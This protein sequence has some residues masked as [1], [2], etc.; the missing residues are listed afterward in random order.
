[1]KRI[2]L[3]IGL[4]VFCAC[5]IVTAFA[6]SSTEKVL[7]SFSNPPANPRDGLVADQA[8]NLYGTA[9]GGG[10]TNS[11]F[12]FK[13]SAPATKGGAWSET[14]LYSFLGG[15][16]D[17]R[18]PRGG[19]VFD[20]A[21][22]LYGTTSYGGANNFGTIFEVSPPSTLGATWV[23]T[24]LY[25]F[26]SHPD[27]FVPWAG[28]I[29]DQA[30]NLY[31]TTQSGGSYACGT[32]FE[33][34]PPATSGGAWTE[35]VIYSF[36]GGHD[37][38]YPVAGLLM[39]SGG[40]LLGTTEYGGACFSAGCGTV[41]RLHYAQ[42]SWTETVLHRFNA[43]EGTQPVAGLTLHGGSFF[44]TTVTGGTAQQGTVFQL[45]LSSSGV[46][47]LLMIHQFGSSAGDGGTPYSGVAF[48][49]AGNLYGTTGYGS[50][51]PGG[52]VY[53]L[54]PPTVSGGTWTETILHEFGSKNDGALPEA[55]L[56]LSKGVLLGTTMQGGS[57]TCN[58]G[59]V[60]S[61]TP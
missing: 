1:M 14:V 22:N 54:S 56:L 26:Q 46:W 47:T 55:G 57:E 3:G 41:F 4:V 7:Y 42:G 16:T 60:F 17:G 61:V 58:C 13:L 2:I 9:A 39:D 28:V 48:D 34:A 44:G 8:G 15:S 53:K 25:S 6:A 12:V 38:C 35:T 40:N 43:A 24:L 11:G 51:N 5:L 18:F 52:T 50:N 32:V 59:T 30:G 49:P 10:T 37:G 36:L 29:V 19:V 33:L 23:E 20:A 45:T 27:G 21:G 31:G